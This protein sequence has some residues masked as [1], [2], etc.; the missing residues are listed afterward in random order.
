MIACGVPERVEGEHTWGSLTL[1][2]LCGTEAPSPVTLPF[3]GCLSSPQ[4]SPCGFALVASGL[5]VTAL[6]QRP[7]EGAWALAPPAREQGRLE[8]LE[9]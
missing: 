8:A 3:F 9:S 7:G 5:V 1:S 4:V 6:P 2:P